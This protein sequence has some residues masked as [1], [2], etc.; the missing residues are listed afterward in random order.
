[1]TVSPP[2]ACASQIDR[3]ANPDAG[4][5]ADVEVARHPLRNAVED[6]GFFLSAI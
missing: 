6:C 4:R 5:T 3:A 2:A 1:L